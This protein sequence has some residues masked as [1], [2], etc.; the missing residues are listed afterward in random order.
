[1]QKDACA[2]RPPPLASL[3]RKSAFQRCGNI[4]AERNCGSDLNE[5]AA[6]KGFSGDVALSSTYLSAVRKESH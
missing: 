2:T 3:S 6:D 5:E 4:G 1:M